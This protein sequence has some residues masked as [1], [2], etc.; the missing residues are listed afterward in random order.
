MPGAARKDG[1]LRVSILA[2]HL[3][4]GGMTRAYFLARVVQAVGHDVEV[5]GHL[6]SGETIYPVPPASIRVLPV[7]RATALLG[8]RGALSGDVVYAVKPLATSFGI[9]L[10]NR[11]LTGRPVLLDIDDWE[12]AASRRP[13]TARASLR[14]VASL[15]RVLTKRNHRLHVAVMERL[16]GRA[17]GVTVNTTFLQ[18]S[19][20]GTYLP[21][22]KD[23]ALFDPARFDP[24]RSRDRL[25]LAPYRVLMFAGT[26]RPHKGLQDVLVAIDGLGE[27]DVRLVL[28]GGREEGDEFVARLM[29]TWGQWIVRLPRAPLEQMPEVIAAAHVVV[30][31]QRDTPVARAQFPLKLTDAMAMAK[32]ILTTRVGDIPAVVGDG[33]YFVDA[34]A[35]EQIAERLRWIFRHP[36]EAAERGRAARARCVAKLSLEPLGAIVSQVLA[37]VA[38]TGARAPGRP[39]RTP[40]HSSTMG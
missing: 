12:V 36:A 2:P 19:Y 24:A 14:R 11:L 40:E 22:G 26:A 1:K 29:Q 21:S 8:R 5:V 15:P 38:P 7:R 9:A 28:V 13:A 31:P 25:G 34:A 37:N 30:V 3:A 20:G 4:R 33:A 6:G 18:R 35:P 10:A 32:P 27:P 17:D 16:I 39:A 23:T